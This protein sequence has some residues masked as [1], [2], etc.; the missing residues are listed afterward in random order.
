MCRQESNALN[1]YC[2]LGFQIYNGCIT[3][4]AVNSSAK[5]AGLQPDHQIVEVNG[6]FVINH[7]DIQI[8]SLIRQI[9]LNCRI[10]TVGL[11][12]IPRRIH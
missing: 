12:V 6:Q 10:H 1:S 11:L 3:A 8:I 5:K 2:D 7:S 4:V 9:L